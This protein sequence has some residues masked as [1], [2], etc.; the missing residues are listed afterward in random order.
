MQNINEVKFY[1]ALEN[2]FTGAK[3]EGDS[4]YINLLKIKFSYYKL[5]LERFKEDVKAKSGIIKDS[6]KEEFFDKLY[7]FF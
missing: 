4:G 7:S 3:I 2:I 5:I 6:F 1:Q